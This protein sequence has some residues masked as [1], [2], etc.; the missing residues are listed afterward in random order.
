MLVI[1]YPEEKLMSKNTPSLFRRIYGILLALSVIASGICLI[2]ACLS[3]YYAGDG[4]SAEAVKAAFAPISVPVYVCLALTV[5]GFVLAAV[6]GAKEKSKPQ[7]NYAYLLRAVK[8]KKD[9]DKADAEV[10]KAVLLERK[11]ILVAALISAAVLVISGAV[12]LIYALDGSHFHTSEINSSMISAMQVMAPCLAICLISGLICIIFTNRSL[13]CEF[14]LY[15]QIPSFI[16]KETDFSALNEENASDGLAK[17]KSSCKKN[18]CEQ[19]NAILSMVKLAI[20]ILAAAALIYGAIAGGT[21]DVLTKAV[22]ICTECI[23]LG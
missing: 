19:K 9:L 23:G 21:A 6:N 4:Y 13:K 5:I 11:K 15:K 14:E 20:L 2:A 18:K 8:S 22:N 3:V 1:L 7:K 12:F 10:K 17:A 16:I